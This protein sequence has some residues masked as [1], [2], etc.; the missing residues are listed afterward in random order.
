M[1]APGASVHL[2][3]ALAGPANV[4]LARGWLGQVSSLHALLT[5]LIH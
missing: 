4:F 3:R 1:A 5:M 2:I